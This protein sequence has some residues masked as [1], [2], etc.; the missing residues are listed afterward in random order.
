MLGKLQACREGI[1]V[2]IWKP[3]AHSTDTWSSAHLPC[4]DPG[5]AVIT[6]QVLEGVIL[7][8]R[9]DDDRDGPPLATWKPEPSRS[10]ECLP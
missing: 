8:M 4:H 1:W 6:L 2:G 10:A 7:F 5:A 9:M 3:V